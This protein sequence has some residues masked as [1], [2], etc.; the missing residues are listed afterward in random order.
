MDVK[1]KI[2]SNPKNKSVWNRFN[3]T[4]GI[5]KIKITDNQFTEGHNYFFGIIGKNVPPSAKCFISVNSV[6]FIEATGEIV[7]FDHGRFTFIIKGEPLWVRRRQAPTLDGDVSVE[8]MDEQ[9][10]IYEG[11]D[12]D[13]DVTAFFDRIYNQYL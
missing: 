10:F 4:P 11:D 3:L 6:I 12:D 9:W 2:V 8:E 5:E 7:A 1:Q 13:D